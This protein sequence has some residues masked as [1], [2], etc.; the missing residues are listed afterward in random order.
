MFQAGAVTGCAAAFLSFR[1]LSF[2]GKPE[3]NSSEKWRSAVWL[4]AMHSGKK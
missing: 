2:T 1:Y 4:N 3:Q